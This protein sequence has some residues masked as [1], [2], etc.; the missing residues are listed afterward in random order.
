MLHPRSFAPVPSLAP[1][2][3]G[4]KEASTSYMN[5]SATTGTSRALWACRVYGIQP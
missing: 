3:K 2:R 4:Q 5:R 1:K